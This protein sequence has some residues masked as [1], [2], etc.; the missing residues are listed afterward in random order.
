M[1]TEAFRSLFV[2]FVTKRID[3]V[4]KD[5]ILYKRRRAKYVPLATDL[6]RVRV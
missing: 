6:F 3:D 2:I 1:G 4:A 5:D